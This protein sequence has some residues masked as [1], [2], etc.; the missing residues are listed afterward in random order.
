MNRVEQA[1][2]AGRQFLASQQR[3]DGGFDGVATATTG[4]RAN[5][6][7]HPTI[8]F[9]ALIAQ[10]CHEIPGAETIKQAACAYLLRHKSEVWSWNYWQRDIDSTAFQQYPD[11]LDDTACALS[12]IAYHDPSQLNG[13][14]L[15]HIGRQLV[16]SE[17]AVGGPYQTWLVSPSL[18]PTWHDID[19]AVNANIAGLLNQVDVMPPGLET[20][21]QQA[22]ERN[23]LKSSYYIGVIPTLYFMAR[24]GDH[25]YRP[26]LAKRI[27]RELQHTKVRTP[28]MTALLLTAGCRTGHP[29]SKLASLAA[30][31]L[32][33]QTDT[34]WPADALYV[35]PP[36]KG[37][38]YV[39][40]SAALTTAFVC[41]ALSLYEHSQRRHIV[42]PTHHVKPNSGM[43]MARRHGP[44]MSQPVIR[45]QY[46]Q[47][48]RNIARRDTD[49]QISRLASQFAHDAGLAIDTTKI[50]YLDA[51]SING[52][53][54]Y[55][56]YDDLLDG[57]GDS[58]Q[59]GMANVA[60]RQ[61]LQHLRRALENDPLFD[62]FAHEVLT[63]IDEANS[64]E[65]TYAQ[66][67]VVDGK[68]RLKHLPAYGD[69]AQLAQRSWGHV[70]ATSGVLLASDYQLDGPDVQ[71]WHCFFH[72]FLIARQLNDD[73]HDWLED[74][75]AGRITAVVAL[76]LA[77]Q[78]LPTTIV[79]G[80]DT[81]RLRQHFWQTT[82]LQVCDLIEDHIQLATTAL[83]ACTFL[84]DDSYYRQLL[85]NL[86]A[87]ASASREGRQEAF[88][89]MHSFGTAKRLA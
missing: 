69:L 64:W 36:V 37:I 30:R 60:Q 7:I 34:H 3:S 71:S 39:A 33:L 11:D 18:L 46:L 43:L 76:L 32:K 24:S 66:Q 38:S 86:T 2:A 63:I 6:R 80:R 59:L 87:A 72:H 82:V 27:G 49:G 54:A 42:S 25:A 19:V 53:I 58:K 65:V 67:P 45:K 70:L 41:E 10:A 88:D 44:T 23:R 5:T 68:I 50:Q 31:L 75:S 51:A 78:Q 81:P 29:A 55:T 56:V 12:A 84:Q 77:A 52:W 28:L 9:T 62:H 4:I 83:D 20:Y 48:L 1:I 85:H 17:V 15:G 73:A 57:E 47:A 16:S 74:L 14:V 22:I 8:F 21:L 61:C 89:F 79:I 13:T 26:A 40:G 35:E